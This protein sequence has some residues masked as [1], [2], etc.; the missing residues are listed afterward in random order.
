[1]NKNLI[2]SIVKIT[3]KEETEI[4]DTLELI[5]V[6]DMYNLIDLVRNNNERDIKSMFESF[7]TPIQYQSKSFDIIVKIRDHITKDGL[8]DWLD[9][10]SIGYML[11][12]SD[13]IVI[14]NTNQDGE[15]KVKQELDSLDRSGD[16][17][18]IQMLTDGVDDNRIPKPRD[19]M[20]KALMLPQYQLKVT[21]NK[22]EKQNKMDRKHMN[23]FVEGKGK[24]EIVG[25]GIMGMTNMTSMLPRLMTLAGMTKADD[26][27]VN[28]IPS[29]IPV[30]SPDITDNYISPSDATLDET[31]N[32][33]II[34]DAFDQVISQMADIRISEFQEVR[35][36]MSNLMS[37]IDRMANSINTN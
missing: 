3:G 37:H 29:S 26:T 36:L 12:P 28:A 24:P 1:M 2:D 18:K 27:G 21:P 13:V 35:D 19:P 10:N 34:R 20:A 11:H 9:D 6:D 4:E 22:I 14:K 32:I 7:T 33:K 16:H 30:I 23:K 17:S 31:E 25:E 15:I 8:L 5:S